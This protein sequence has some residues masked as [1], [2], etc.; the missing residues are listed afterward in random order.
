M[1]SPPALRLRRIRWCFYGNPR[2]S[3]TLQLRRDAEPYV[4]VAFISHS[5]AFA[6]QADSSSKTRYATVKV[7]GWT[8]LQRRGLIAVGLFERLMT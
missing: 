4:I 3:D 5:S 7:W 1:M 2:A 8:D 6:T